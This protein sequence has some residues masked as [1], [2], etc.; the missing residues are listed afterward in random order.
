MDELPTVKIL[1]EEEI[2]WK[3]RIPTNF[4]Y[5]FASIK[6]CKICANSE[7][8]DYSAPMFTAG[9]PVEIISGYIKQK[10]NTLFSIEEM[11]AHI[12]HITA[13]HKSVDIDAELGKELNMI[14]GDI[15]VQINEDIALDSALRSLYYKKVKMDREGA[16]PK[17]YNDNMDRLIKT[18]E[19]KHRKKLRQK[20][21]ADRVGIGDLFDIK[22]VRKD[23]TNNDTENTDDEK[24]YSE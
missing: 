12:E 9:V 8:A 23:V 7:V 22:I 3:Y 10:F 2:R 21:D 24:G 11:I 1:D 15:K 14:D 5:T 17:E 18:I 19:L 13:V 20:G 6:E 16:D 4:N